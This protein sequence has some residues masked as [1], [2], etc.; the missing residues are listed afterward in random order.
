MDIAALQLA[1][2]FSLVPHELGYCHARNSAA[3]TFRKCLAGGD[4]RGVEEEISHF[5]VLYPYLK[6]LAEI[7][8][9][10]PFSYQVIESY[11]LGNDE[12]KKAKTEHYDLLLENFAKQG[13][14]A[15]LIE[16]LSQ[17]QPKVF[18]PTHLFQ[19]LHVGVGRASGSVPFN[20]DSINQ[21]MVR[22]GRVRKFQ[23]RV[24][25]EVN[26]LEKKGKDY[27]LT[28]KTETLRFEP[29]FMPGLKVGDCIACHWGWAVK[30]LTA[31]EEKNLSFWTREVLQNSRPMPEIASKA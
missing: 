19:V 29:K 8:G 6:T 30:I 1:A 10:S 22:W 15:W 27:R 4:C 18:T 5:I 23:I 24:T 25:A 14:P 12:L 17:N 3:K 28:F 13:V 7:I 16:E 20:L 11:W 26:S 2:R 21:C 9:L 31:R